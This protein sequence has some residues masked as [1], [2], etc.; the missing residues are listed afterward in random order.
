MDH[1]TEEESPILDERMRLGWGDAALDLRVRMNNL[2]FEDEIGVRLCR[3][4]T[5][6]I[7]SLAPFIVM[8]ALM[9]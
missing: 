1:R 2:S 7:S 9:T 6:S 3:V 4:R 8:N 5:Q